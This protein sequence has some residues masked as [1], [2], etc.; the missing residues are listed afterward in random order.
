[1]ILNFIESLSWIQ[2][3]VAQI[4]Y[5]LCIFIFLDNIFGKKIRGKYYL[6]H[7]ICN[8]YI[9]YLT[10]PDV[11][12]TYKYFIDVMQYPMNYNAAA[13]TFALHFYHIIL[14]FKN[15]SLAFSQKLP[16]VAF[17]KRTA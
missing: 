10:F 15:P 8:M 16:I 1:M 2:I 6:I 3:F 13:V 12:Y 7:S 17:S 14:Y 11:I 5:Y 9:I 4:F